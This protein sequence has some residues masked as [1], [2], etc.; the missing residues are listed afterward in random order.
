MVFFDTSVG[1]GKKLLR[2]IKSA[3]TRP[4]LKFFWSH[5]LEITNPLPIPSMYGIFTY[6]WL[7]FMVNVGKYIIHGSYGLKPKALKS[8]LVLYVLLVISVGFSGTEVDGSMVIGLMGSF[9]YLY[10][11]YMVVSKNSGTPKSSILIGFS[12]INHPF[13]GT[14]IFGNTHIGII[15][16][17]YTFTFDPNFLP[18]TSKEVVEFQRIWKICQIGSFPYK[19][20]KTWKK[21][22]QTT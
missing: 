18:V 19:S 11:W 8:Q 9:N 4:A 13:W 16:H 12:I 3:S 14:T 5:L 15:T 17:L 6:I 1:C 2:K 7:K 10:M 22:K 21:L 20:G